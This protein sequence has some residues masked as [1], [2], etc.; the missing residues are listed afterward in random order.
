MSPAAL[1]FVLCFL[2]AVSLVFAANMRIDSM[3]EDVNQRLP[4]NAQISVWDR[5]K[6]FE[7]LRLHAE[8]HPESPKRWQMC[9]LALTGFAFGFG[10]F[11]ASWILPP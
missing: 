2:V 1:T 9:T 5:S 6:M 4:A 10:G 11:I 3:C 7:L 8:M